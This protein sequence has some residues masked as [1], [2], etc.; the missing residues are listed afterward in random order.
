MNGPVAPAWSVNLTDPKFTRQLSDAECE[1]FSAPVFITGSLVCVE[2]VFW[3]APWATWI[4][5]VR[6]RTG[7]SFPQGYREVAVEELDAYAAAILGVQR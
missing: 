7:R 6:D 2:V 1:A 5:L 4:V 3:S